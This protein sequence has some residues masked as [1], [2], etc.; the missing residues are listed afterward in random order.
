MKVLILFLSLISVASAQDMDLNQRGLGPSPEEAQGQLFFGLAQSQHSARVA[1]SQAKMYGQ[2]YAATR[3]GSGSGGV[4]SVAQFAA[5]VCAAGEV[6]P[7]GTQIGFWAKIGTK[8]K[9]CR[10]AQMTARYAM[11]T[12]MAMISG[13]GIQGCDKVVDDTK[14]VGI[15]G[16]IIDGMK[17]VALGTIGASVADSLLDNAF[18]MGSAAIAANTAIAQNPA[19]TQVITQPVPIEPTIV[20]PAVIEIPVLDDT[21]L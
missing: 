17:T 6:K 13:G 8:S 3:A 21:E 16:K 1:A 9:K 15:W 14:W 11:C 19:P 20:N 5:Q 4:A 2:L 7:D 12:E 18:G 10:E